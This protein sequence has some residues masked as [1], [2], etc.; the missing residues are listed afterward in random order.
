MDCILAVGIAKELDEVVGEACQDIVA[1]AAGL[2]MVV[3]CSALVSAV[4]GGCGQEQWACQGVDTYADETAGWQ[5]QDG[6]VEL[7]EWQP[8][9]ELE[10]GLVLLGGVGALEE[11]VPSE[12]VQVVGKAG[13]ALKWAG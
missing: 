8:V 12:E 4:G 7:Q 1:T 9:I 2:A 5:K 11:G 6:E 13:V 10:K 3:A